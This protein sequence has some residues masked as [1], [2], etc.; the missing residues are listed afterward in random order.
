MFSPVLANTLI[1]VNILVIL[2]LALALTIQREVVLARDE[3]IGELMT[4]ADTAQRRR[5]QAEGE[6]DDAVRLIATQSQQIGGH[7]RDNL[8][9]CE[10]VRYQRRHGA[11]DELDAEGII[12]EIEAWLE[13]EQ[14]T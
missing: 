3:R 8:I 2:I 1:L 14:V 13:G 4:D 9:L 10:E 5:E 7:L 12:D 11:P 6:R